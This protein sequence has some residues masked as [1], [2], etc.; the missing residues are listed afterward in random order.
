MGGARFVVHPLAD[1]GR[2]HHGAHDWGGYFRVRRNSR[3][4]SF[5]STSFAALF[6]VVPIIGIMLEAVV[7][8]ISTF[9]ALQT[10]MLQSLTIWFAGS[11]TSVFEGQWEILL[12]VL[13]VLVCVWIFAD[14]LTVAGLGEDIATNVGL[15]YNRIILA[16][17]GLI[18]VA[19]GVVT[20]VIGQ[21]PFL[22]LIVPNIVSLFRGDD[23]RSNLPWVVLVGI[24]VVTVCD[25]FARTVISPFEVP[26]SVVLGIVGT[27][28]FVE[29]ILKG[30]KGNA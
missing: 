25:L 10:D 3:L 24:A 5:P 14:R 12:I 17:T 27:I 28:V 13:V 22:G 30:R 16:G 23:L 8:S 19:S 20:V 29:L 9:F 6:L 1:P 2:K 7:S 4:L 11:F 15:N 21:L 26:V 18:A